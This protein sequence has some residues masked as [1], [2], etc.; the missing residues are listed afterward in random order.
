MKIERDDEIDE[1][2]WVQIKPL[3]KKRCKT[4]WTF[5]QRWGAWKNFNCELVFVNMTEALAL[6][7]ERVQQ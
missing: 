2:D 1:N 7:P 4:S 3:S 5:R 6:D